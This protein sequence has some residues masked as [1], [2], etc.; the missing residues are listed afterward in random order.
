LEE[1]G[2]ETEGGGFETE[3][4]EYTYYKDYSLSFLSTR[5]EK[6]AGWLVRRKFLERKKRVCFYLL[7]QISKHNMQQPQVLP[8]FPQMTLGRP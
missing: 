5:K 2:L 8:P 1:D 6:L 7:K 4:F 3:T